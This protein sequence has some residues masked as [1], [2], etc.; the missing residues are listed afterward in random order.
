MKKNIFK[1]K[2]QIIFEQITL[3]Y[4]T[5]DLSWCTNDKID[6]QRM[7]QLI[8][9]LDPHNSMLSIA[10]YCTTTVENEIDM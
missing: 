2:N 4:S 10:V 1:K 6:D 7:P 9:V 3:N 8:D 5:I